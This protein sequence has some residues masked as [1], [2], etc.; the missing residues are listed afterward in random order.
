MTDNCH[1][2]SVYCNTY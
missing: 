1:S 2:I